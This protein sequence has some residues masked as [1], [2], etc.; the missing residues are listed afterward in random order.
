MVKGSGL[1]EILAKNNLPIIGT[2]AVINANHIKQPRYCLQVAVRAAYAKRKDVAVKSGLRL[3]SR[4]LS[5][6]NVLLL[7]HDY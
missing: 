3:Y 6:S 1:Y 7:G 2:G 5:V 4:L